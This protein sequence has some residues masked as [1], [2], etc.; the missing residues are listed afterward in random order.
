VYPILGIKP[1]KMCKEYCSDKNPGRLKTYLD[2]YK[3]IILPKHILLIGNGVTLYI[4]PD[5]TCFP[6]RS[7]IR[8]K[9]NQV[10]LDNSIV[11]TKISEDNSHTRIN[12]STSNLNAPS[13]VA[14]YDHDNTEANDSIANNNDRQLLMDDDNNDV[15]S[16]QS[17]DSSNHSDDSSTHS[18]DS[19]TTEP[20]FSMQHRNMFRIP[21]KLGNDHIM[22]LTHCSKDHFLQFANNLKPHMQKL[23]LKLLSVYGRAFLFRLKESFVIF[24]LTQCSGSK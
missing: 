4:G 18:D 15:P 19:V 16:G 7:L 8:Y 5:Y 10:V 20:S 2:A 17:D 3:Q 11:I 1:Y 22:N 6:E 12:N 21:Q 24:F 13:S 14:S 23:D 9:L